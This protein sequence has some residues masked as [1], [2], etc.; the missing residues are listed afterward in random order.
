MPGSKPAQGIPDSVQHFLKAFLPR[1]S[2]RHN[3]IGAIEAQNRP[4]ACGTPTRTAN[5][6]GPI[7]PVVNDQPPWQHG[8]FLNGLLPPLSSEQVARHFV[9]AL[10]M[11]VRRSSLRPPPSRQVGT[12]APG[13]H[14][15]VTC[16]GPFIRDCRSCQPAARLVLLSEASLL[17]EMRLRVRGGTLDSKARI[18]INPQFSLVRGTT[19]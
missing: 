7:S 9:E 11:G 13:E 19:D 16:S 12:G 2:S 5:H 10:E 1:S 6:A 3:H 15:P 17:R 18:I 14:D 8:D 4:V